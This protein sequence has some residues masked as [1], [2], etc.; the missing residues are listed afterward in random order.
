MVKVSY[1]RGVD[2]IADLTI[3][4]PDDWHVHVRDDEMLEAVVGYSAR[5]FRYCLIMP[6]LVP[7][8]DTVEAARAYRERIVAAASAEPPSLFEPIMSLY[9]T[10][11]LTPE[12]VRRGWEQGIV[13][14][15]K[16]YPAGATTN[17]ASG[18]TSLRAFTPVLE[19]LA[20]LGAPLFVH[21]ES[22]DPSVDIFARE[23][24]F[25]EDEV[26]P[27]CE[28]H[29]KLRVTVEH[30]S[31]RI[32]VELVLAYPN[33][34]ATIT[35]HHLR[36]TRSDILA[37]GLRPELYCK[38][39]INSAQDR[40]ALVAAAT[41]GNEKFFLGTDSAPHPL[42]AKQARVAKAGIFNAPYALE[43][44]AEV[45][46]EA[47]ALGALADFVS[48]NGARRYGK[49]VP[50]QEIRLRRWAEPADEPV[51]VIETAGGE[52]VRLFG[53]A[54]AARWDIDPVI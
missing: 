36:C 41:S 44:T 51:S 32:G 52:S 14:G 27:L 28:D 46:F 19:T 10:E 22:T 6:N 5:R 2:V 4:V 40:E 7:P 25:L 54:E 47:D 45:F 12:E 29:P 11:A 53:V 3:P 43:V 24:R 42:S 17:S 18:G 39:V 13:G 38:P 26:A 8:V 1:P 9:L 37:N 48:R 33:V 16:F 35:P 20:E 50:T 49:D 23:A 15:V 30:L 31:T 34:A 21:A